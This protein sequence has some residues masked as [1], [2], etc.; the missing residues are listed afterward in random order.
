ML[1]RTLTIPTARVYTPLLEPRRF[2]GAHGGRGS[3]KSH[4]FAD[5]AIERAM[6]QPGTRGLMI[7][8]HQ[9]TL[10][11]SVKPLIESK[12]RAMGLQ[13]YFLV[14]ERLIRTPGGGEFTFQG[15][16]NHTADSVK[17][18][19]G[20]DFAWVEE[21][22]SLTQRSLTLLTPT[23]RKPNSEI[24]FSWNRRSPTDPVDA[25]FREHKD[26]PNAVCVQANYYDNPWFPDVL[27]LE[28]E[29]CKRHDPEKY[30]HVWL[31]DYQT[32]SEAVVFQHGRHWRIGDP[33]EFKPREE[34]QRFYYG[35][36]FGFATDP[37]CM[38]ECYIEGRNLYV[39]AEVYEV[40]VEIDYLPFL[41]G[42]CSDEQLNRLNL[43]AFKELKP[44]QK[45]RWTGIPGCRFWPIIADSARPETI[46][47]LRRHGFQAMQPARKGSGSVEEGIEF[48]KGFTIVVHP[49]CRHT[50]DELTTYSYKIDPKTE[51]VLPVLVDAKN[52]AIDS[53]RYAVERLRKP[54]LGIF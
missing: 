41:F 49:D 24:W 15:M 26:D 37:A 20:Y 25:F 18:F 9:T 32:R 46:S 44:A 1:S 6:L 14:Q 13:S 28:M 38:V 11:Q 30:R 21:A 48:L 34:V 53:L 8:E 22:Q 33:S 36:D 31:G 12:I 42:G 3:G 27:K 52:H 54:K 29:W 17:S 43:Q 45:D 16:A 10:R 4:F 2:K 23:I 51:E 47:Y 19:E 40:G 50:I 35:A 7:R 5:L 39:T